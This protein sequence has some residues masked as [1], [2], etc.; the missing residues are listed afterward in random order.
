MTIRIDAGGPPDNDTLMKWRAEALQCL[1]DPDDWAFFVVSL[2]VAAEMERRGIENPELPPGMTAPERS[3]SALM[4][5]L[6]KQ[7]ILMKCGDTGPFLR[8]Y[9]A[10]VDLANGR[11]SPLFKPV[12]RRAGNPGKGLGYEAVKGIAGKAIWIAL[13]QG[14]T[15]RT[16]QPRASS[17]QS[18][19]PSVRTWRI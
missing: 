6:E 14:E 9:S 17:K 16:T 18:K 3:L 11:P 19:N 5:F 15:V 10:I 13:L 2:R 8:L 7:H 1:P 12:E 4:S